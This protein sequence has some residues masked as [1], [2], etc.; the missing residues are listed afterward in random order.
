MNLLLD[1]LAH[2]FFVRAL[3]AAILV[4]TVCAV[5][6]T[7]VVLRGLAFI[8]DAIS[9]A[10]FPGVV[11]AYV[12]KGP[13]LVGA[14]VAAVARG[15]PDVAGVGEGDV[16][17]ADVG[18]LEEAGGLGGGDGRP[19]A[20]RERRGDEACAHDGTGL[21][22][23]RGRQRGAMAEDAPAGRR[24]RGRPA[25]RPCSAVIRSAM[26]GGTRAWDQPLCSLPNRIT[27]DLPD[28]DIPAP[29]NAWT[30][31]GPGRHQR[32]FDPRAASRTAVRWATV[33]SI[34]FEPRFGLMRVQSGLLVP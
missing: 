33:P 24:A 21:S 7:Y 3:L 34:G 32:D 18:L 6:G 27:A 14:G 30:A 15:E 19:E 13:F 23:G 29:I 28:R 12:F 10:A 11:A 16:A 1:P 20:E 25:G 31:R 8:G 9:H 22:C 26:H 5:V 4:G 17:R 2:P